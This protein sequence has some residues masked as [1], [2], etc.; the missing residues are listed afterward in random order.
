MSIYSPGQM[1]VDDGE[2]RHGT[3]CAV[4]GSV[5]GQGLQHHNTRCRSP[6]WISVGGMV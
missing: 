3:G 6:G 2:A 5:E 4:H 1:T